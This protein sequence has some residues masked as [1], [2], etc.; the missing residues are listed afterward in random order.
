MQYIQFQP[1]LSSNIP[2]APVGSL[3]FYID[4]TN[5]TLVFKDENGQYYEYLSFITVTKSEID[6]IITNNALVA[7]WYYRING[8]NTGLYGGTDIILKATSTNQLERRGVG[9]FYNPKYESYN[10]W[11]NCDRVNITST[12]GFFQFGETIHGDQ[13]QTGNLVTLPGNSKMT[14]INTN[15][16]WSQ[17]ETIY[18]DYSS[19]TTV[20]TGYISQAKYNVGDK[21]IWGG[22]VWVNLTGNVGST[23]GDPIHVLDNTNWSGLTYN[24]IDYNLVADTIEY[25]YQ[26]NNISYRADKTNEVI[27]D[28]STFNS[29]WE[30][31]QIGNFPWGHPRVTHVK[32]DNS[33]IDNFI[34]FPNTNNSNV[35]FVEVTNTS[36]F[37]A[38]FWGVDTSIT[39]L[40]ITNNS[41]ID[42]VYFGDSS[43]ITY[44]N[45]DNGS[46]FG[47]FY[48]SNNDY[49]ITQI[50]NLDVLESSSFYNLYF[51]PNSYLRY[52]YIHG[53]SSFVY[54]YLYNAYLSQIRLCSSS[55]LG[56][57]ALGV[58][59]SIY[60]INLISS[61][62]EGVN[63]GVS[64]G[65][66][67]INMGN[68]SFMTALAISDYSVI[69]DIVI[70]SSSNIN[71]INM[72]GNSAEMGYIEL[73]N[74]SY[75][76]NLTLGTSSYFNYIK[77]NTNSSLVN[78]T[79]N[80]N[81]GLQN[82]ELGNDYY[83]S[84]LTISQSLND[85]IINYQNS[86]FP[87]TID[88]SNQT[89]IDLSD[90]QHVGILNLTSSNSSETI[91]YLP[92]GRVG[93]IQILQ[94]YSGLTLT[95][96]NV[97]VSS[98]NANGEIITTVSNIVLYG[99]SFDYF[100]FQTITNG[101]YS[102]VKELNSNNYVNNK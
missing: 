64:S 60:N 51:Y 31:N 50:Q 11:D 42:G 26:N 36:Q 35:S 66:Y 63:L 3:N 65:L 97:G 29:L 39:Y 98:I 30:F 5:N 62:I 49:N 28:Y 77:I 38:S 70:N 95:I 45:V 34:N 99:I 92:N 67:N 96:N 10:V 14:F 86:N 2:N 101:L 46:F 69:N 13:G 6:T 59:S 47:E 21:V 75:I 16:D 54:A 79:I 1:Q 85:I 33:Y 81:V 82:F 61:Y 71:G 90:I 68:N 84:N 89:T 56:Y 43:N 93:M 100:R 41:A 87:Q 44:I 12:T 91:T 25:D 72:T 24:I 102:V 18:G 32:I 37:D 17:T 4:S 83:I 80:A 19:A 53:S 7:G 8:V 15:G 22:T 52:M 20:Y 76:N 57:C 23:T 40:R 48:L 73:D 94:P 78:P 27:A 58:G 55:T 9:F 74:S 88:I